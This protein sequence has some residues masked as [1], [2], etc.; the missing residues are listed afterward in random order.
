MNRLI[1][2]IT[3]SIQ[4]KLQLFILS[5]TVIVF[6][7]TIIYVSLENR[8]MALDEAKRLTMEIAQKRAFEIE[9]ELNKDF[10]L[11]HTLGK[12]FQDFVFYN[13]TTR[14]KILPSMLKRVFEY[15]S[16][17]Q[18]IWMHWE[19][20]AIDDNY[21]NDYGRVRKNFF[22][23]GSDIRFKID[24]VDTEGDNEAGLYYKI[25][26]N[27]SNVITEPYWYSYTGDKADE[28][29]ETSIC[30][31][32]LQSTKFLGLMGID[33][34]LARF[35]D[36]IK[37]IK[38]FPNSYAFFMS[39]EGT[40]IYHPDDENIGE[41]LIKDNQK[42]N[43][44][45]DIENRIKAGEQFSF[46]RS[47]GNKNLFATFAPVYIGD[48]QTPWYLSIVVPNEQMIIQ[49]NQN[50][51]KSLLIGLAGILIL[52]IVLFF[53]SR[54]ITRPLVHISGLLKELSQGKI[55]AGKE[56][57]IKTRDEIGSISMDA[58]ELKKNLART[59]KFAE[60]IGKGNLDVDFQKLSEEDVLGS[61]LLNMRA[62][63]QH[64]EEEEEKRK[65]EDQIQRWITDGI[66]RINELMRQHDNLSEL[67][68]QVVK[69]IADYLDA[70]QGALYV[71]AD[72]DA[73]KDE[74][75]ITFEATSALAW[76]RKKP[77][78]RTIKMGE[79]LVGRA[80]YERD[81]L[82]VTDVPEE[83][84]NITS[85][86]GKA[87]PRALLIVPLI[88]NDEV[89][90]VLEIISFNK[91]EQY[92][93]DFVKKAG[94]SIASTIASLKISQH[95]AQL[96]EQTKSQAGELTEKEEEL[97]QQMEEMQATQEEAAKREAEMTGMITAVNSIAF[98]A[99]FDM[100]GFITSVNDAYAQLLE[101]P[102][103][104]IVGK[105]QG[106]FEIG[107]DKQRIESFEQLWAKMRKG[108]PYKQEQKIDI[109]N[110]TYWLSEVYTPIKD[111]DGVPQRVINI[112]MDITHLKE[113]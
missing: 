99:E 17:I 58:N 33:L 10:A 12:A 86:L 64:A 93:I 40:F 11:T 80:A 85:G 112:A 26:T 107:E 44:K 25:K 95:T 102:K 68:Y 32:V 4:A 2:K 9:S 113:K 5:S 92:Q 41:N 20:N 78:H 104:Q 61:A 7:L 62:S 108:I 46:I 79:T 81:T 89:M 67:S 74:D 42:D 109:N 63:L 38:P 75:E 110:K 69:Y 101:M 13:D 82:Y 6:L 31:P 8:D 27:K 73:R 57:E 14:E 24:T 28:I 21:L 39:H 35:E 51:R 56:L 106:F 83:Y 88:L 71:V 23:V 34:K 18:S 90:G 48:T 77:L 30:V 19:L 15:N 111:N 36:L 60:E 66:A 29:L 53:I 54:N 70:N 105:K 59:A 47:K 72:K 16:H 65:K 55:N 52:A 84:V 103:Q 37:Q 49:A 76:G 98:V 43:E 97:R 94:G 50:M 3:A 22:R 45:Y 1:K 91:F 100:D 87:T 96:L